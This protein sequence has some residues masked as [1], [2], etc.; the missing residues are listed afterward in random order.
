VHL[1]GLFDAV[2][3]WLILFAMLNLC[4]QLNTGTY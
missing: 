3:W 2:V 1:T 4:R